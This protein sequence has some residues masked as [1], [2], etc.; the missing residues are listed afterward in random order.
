MYSGSEK[1][2][3]PPITFADV[4]VDSLN[5]AISLCTGYN[6]IALTELKLLGIPTELLYPHMQSKQV[7]GNLGEVTDSEAVVHDL[8]LLRQACGDLGLETDVDFMGRGYISK[9]LKQRLQDHILDSVPE[10]FR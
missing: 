4:P 10:V 7:F 2:G 5:R 3:Q 8:D 1:E 9:V 6:W